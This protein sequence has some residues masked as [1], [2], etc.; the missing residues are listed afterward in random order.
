[1]SVYI[2]PVVETAWLGRRL[3]PLAVIFLSVLFLAHNN[4]NY[5]FVS[6]LCRASSTKKSSVVVGF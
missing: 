6:D 3:L 4:I 2:R 1:M 5:T